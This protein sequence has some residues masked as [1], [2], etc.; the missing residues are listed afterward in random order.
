MAA[1]AVCGINYGSNI[2]IDWLVVG[3]LIA[4]GGVISTIS[5]IRS[6]GYIAQTLA[7]PR[8][9]RLPVY[10]YIRVIAVV[11]V[12]VFHT[13]NWDLSEAASLS[14]TGLYTGLDSLR[15]WSLICNMLFIMISGALLLPGKKESILLFYKK[16]LVRIVIPLVV[17]FIWYLWQYNMLGDMT[18]W[19]VIVMI[20]IGDVAGA[21]VLH[22]WII[23][24]MLFIYLLV[25]VLRIA[26]A[27]LSRRGLNILVLCIIGFMTVGSFTSIFDSKLIMTVGYIGAAIMGYYITREENRIYD[28]AYLVMGVAATVFMFVIDADYPYFESLV[29][30]L[31][32]LRLFICLGVFVIFIRIK[33]SLKDIYA[34]RL[35]S[36]YS[37]SIMLIHMWVLYYI[38][39][40]LVPISAVMYHGL[41]LV[42]S[43]IITLALS[44][45]MAYLID[46][47]IVNILMFLLDKGRRVDKS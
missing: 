26:L 43:V 45:I 46:N 14:G 22:F 33:D 39:R 23:Y 44:I 6:E 41:G 31:S 1:V 19:D 34:I 18:P 7:I 8:S 17:Y 28:I 30:N 20:C 2:G 29:G 11:L 9:N 42:I 13:L 38:T 5:S 27:K 15:W 35:V 12:I 21:R 10:D 24:E 40:K 4:V 3:A 36:K 25:P 37:Y 32:I 16:R 47:F